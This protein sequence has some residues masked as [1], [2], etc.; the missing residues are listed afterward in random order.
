[1]PAT[2]TFKK[3]VKNNVVVDERPHVIFRI[4]PWS[5]SS[6]NT[7]PRTNQSGNYWCCFRTKSSIPKPIYTYMDGC[8]FL[9]QRQSDS[10]VAK[11]YT[12][13]TFFILF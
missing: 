9:I 5:A 3:E 1:M 7:V 4:N 2:L 11:P 8:D 6:R 12:I 13:K 10:H